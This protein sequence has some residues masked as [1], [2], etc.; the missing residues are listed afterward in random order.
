MSSNM[1]LSLFQL[2]QGSL[3][4]QAGGDRVQDPGV[5]LYHHT[6]HMGAASFPG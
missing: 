1:H 6:P 5:F 3:L 4:Q 2:G